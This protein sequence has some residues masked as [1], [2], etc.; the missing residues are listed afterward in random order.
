MGWD[1]VVRKPAWPKRSAGLAGF[2]FYGEL[3][4]VKSG[5]AI[6]CAT[7]TAAGKVAQLAAKGRFLILERQ[8]A[9]RKTG[10]VHVPP[11]REKAVLG[12]SRAFWKGH[13]VRNGCKR[14]FKAFM[15]EGVV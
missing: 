10:G 7:F 4:F 15:G 12:H 5:P 8:G 14:A 11:R 13:F 6:S 2:P 9:R 1:V 3:H